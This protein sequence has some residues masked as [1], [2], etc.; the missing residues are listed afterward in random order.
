MTTD[1]SGSVSTQIPASS[2][3]NVTINDMSSNTSKPISG[4]NVD[5]VTNKT[6]YYILLSDPTGSIPPIPIVFNINDV[7]SSPQQT[8]KSSSLIKSTNYVSCGLQGMGAILNWLASSFLDVVTGEVKELKVIINLTKATSQISDM[9]DSAPIAIET[10]GNNLN[11]QYFRNILLSQGTTYLCRGSVNDAAAE[12]TAIFNYTGGVLTLATIFLPDMGISG[13]YISTRKFLT[14]LN[15]VIFCFEGYNNDAV[16]DWYYKYGY[17]IPVP[18]TQQNQSPV[19]SSVT[20]NPSTVNPNGTS[21][22]TCSASDPD[23]NDVLAY[24]WEATGGTFPITRFLPTVTW[25]A[26]S[27]SGTYTVTCTV[28][29]GKGGTASKGVNIT[30]TEST[31][32]L[33]ITTTSLPSGTVGVSY[34]ANL[35]ATGG[36]TPYTWSITNGNLPLGLSLSTGGLISGT[37]TTAGTYN[38]TIQVKDSSSP[39]Q[40]APKSLSITITSGGYSI[41]GRVT[42]NGSGFSEVT[43]TGTGLTPT[44]T[45]SNGNY[46]FGGAQNGSYTITPSKSGYTFTPS[47]RSITV[48]NANYTVPDFTATQTTEGILSVSPSDRFDSSGS[49]GGPFSPSSK[50]YTLSNTGGSSINWTSSKGQSWVSLS[51]TSGTLSPGG[52]TTVTVSINSNANS[53]SPSNYVDTVSFTNTTNGNGNTTRTVNLTVNYS[54]PTITIGPTS[55]NF[56]SVQVGTCS[57]AVFAIQHVLGTGPASG[58]VSAS[59]NPPFSILSGSS[60]SVSNGSAANVTVQFCPTSGGTFNGTAIVSSSATFTGTNTVTLTGTGTAP[61][62]VLS[63]SP[64]DRFDSSGLQGGPFSP[65]SKTYTLSNTGGSS[66]NWTASKG[67]SWVNLSAT[68]GTLSPG[69]NTTVTVSINSNANSLS[70]GNYV[71]IVNFTNTTNGNGNQ[72]R[73]I[74]LTVNYSTPTITVG[75]TSLNFGSVQVGTCTTAVFVIQH[76]L[77]TGPASGTVSA[78]PNPPFSILSGSSFSVSNGSA[79]NVTVQFCPTSSGT[80]N[81]TATVSSSAT[82]TGTNTVTLT[83]TG[84]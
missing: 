37:P 28:S 51:S 8:I 23:V 18:V 26:P 83:G 36:K 40:T 68:I 79:A 70:P 75:P 9:V 63:V 50:T 48:N 33:S 66:I 10:L 56:G 46:A 52:S 72:S 58:T 30:V 20:P 55:V 2:A 78:S 19:I 45:D 12:L 73:T 44:T 41:S 74:N 71:D 6:D 42:L 38:F 53:L 64:T 7:N 31:T 16:F 4:F 24:S 57:T 65:S 39:Q 47:S 77:G 13:V 5:V 17:L 76:V 34:G 15:S 22:V 69:G 80:F 25:I 27:T 54:T 59:P 81:G 62:G 60:F 21:T 49:Q 32:P 14:Q 43:M 82:F 67:Q 29:D 1:D 35:S 84:F 11:A 61:S 3:L